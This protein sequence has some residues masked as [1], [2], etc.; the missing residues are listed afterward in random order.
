MGRMAGDAGTAGGTG[1]IDD[2]VRVSRARWAR[3]GA[4]GKRIG[5]G[6]VLASI[7]V[8]VVGAATRFTG[9]VTGVVT[10]CLIGSTFTLAPGIVIGYAVKKAEREDPEPLRR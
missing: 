5:Y 7:A 1:P 2:P 4:M 6:L 10:A 8:F 3:W 9:L